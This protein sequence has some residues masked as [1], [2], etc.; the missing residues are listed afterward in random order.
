MIFPV[1]YLKTILFTFFILCNVCGYFL[2][3]KKFFGLQSQNI[4]TIFILG[5]SFLIFFSYLINFF[6]PL[7]IYITNI[8]FIFFSIMGLI[9]FVI[10]KNINFRYLIIIVFITSLITFLSKSYNDYE[11]YHLPYMEILRKFKIIFGLSN[12]DFRYGHTSV[13]QNISAFQYNSLML[14]DSYVFYTPLLTI[15]S[16]GYLYNKL[17]KTRN[18]FILLISLSTLIY[19]LLHGSR[20]GALGND[21]PTHILAVISIILFIEIKNN[22]S[23]KNENIFLF[24]TIILI[25]TLSKFSLILFYLLPVYL[26]LKR[27][28]FIDLKNIFLLVLLSFFFIKNFINTSCLVYPIS[29]LCF[30]TKWSVNEYSYTSPKTISMESSAMVKAYMESKYL[31]DPNL[32]KN[33][34]DNLL[35]QDSSKKFLSL[36]PNHEK[37]EYI[38]FQYYKYYSQFK[39]WFPEYLKG[40][41]FLKLLKNI[42]FLCFI[43]FFIFYFYLKSQILNKINLL[44][45]LTKFFINNYFITIFISINFLL[46]LINFPQL[47]YGLSYVLVFSMLPSIVVYGNCNLHRVEKIFR[48]L[49]ILSFSYAILSNSLRIFKESKNYNQINDILHLQIVPLSK[50]DYKTIKTNDHIDIRQPIGGVCSDIEQLCSVFTDRFLLTQRKIHKSANNYIIIK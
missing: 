11:L 27:K 29:F 35:E 47:R 38:N 37:S 32:K 44:N 13:F 1:L 10:D 15:L 16:A 50:F 2:L 40:N 19:Y 31:I 17:F 49:I 7:N 43:I 28:I 12:F 39:I 45:L 34:I 18:N 4:F 6:S 33:F 24:L 46:W 25:I 3:I 26:V 41:D 9:F 14:K 21:L 5:S 36:L 20:Y 8:F 30:E 42:F 23:N 22:N 48:I